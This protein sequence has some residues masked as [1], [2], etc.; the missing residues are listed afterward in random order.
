MVC[1]SI[2]KRFFYAEVLG[3]NIL[4]TLLSFNKEFIYPSSK[5]RMNMNIILNYN[6]IFKVYILEVTGKK[7]WSILVNRKNLSL[8]VQLKLQFL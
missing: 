2:T 3:P 7:K 1:D 8:L 6:C 5:K 4:W